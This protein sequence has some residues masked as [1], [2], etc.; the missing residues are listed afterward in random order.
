MLE[1]S[2][3]VDVQSL[4]LGV[5]RVEADLLARTQTVGTLGG[6]RGETLV[7]GGQSSSRYGLAPPRHAVNAQQPRE[8]IVT[9]AS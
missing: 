1:T 2:Q 7:E 6:H 5:E 9:T 8:S 4:A 3:A